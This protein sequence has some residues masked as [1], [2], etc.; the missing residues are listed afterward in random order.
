[1]PLALLRRKRGA[2]QARF[3]MGDNGDGA[4][5]VLR[6]ITVFGGAATGFIA[7]CTITWFLFNIISAAN[8]QP[9]KNEEFTRRAAFTEAAIQAMQLQLGAHEFRITGIR[10]DLEAWRGSDQKFQDEMRASIAEVTRILTDVRL[11]IAKSLVQ[12]QIH[13]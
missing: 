11:T 10:S 2:R 6:Q 3:E 12:G 4:G 5:R 13:K 8:S 1:M 9:A 7:I